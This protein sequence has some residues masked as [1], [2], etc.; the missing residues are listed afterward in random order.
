MSVDE[1][2]GPE[3]FPTTADERWLY[4]VNG[5]N[6][7]PQPDGRPWRA[8]TWADFRDTSEEEPRWL[9][10]GLIPE[11][12]L[13]FTA[14]PPKK[15]KTW[16]A[17]GKALSL[18]TGTALFGEYVV[19]EAVPVLYVALEGSRS[20]LRA[21]IGSLARGMG[22][23][24]DSPIEN[25][26]MLYRPRPF[27][28]AELVSATWLHEEVQDV[29]ARYVVIDVLRAA[30]R[31]QEKD[32]SDF[33]LVRDAL[34]P[35]LIEGVTVDLLHHFGK[36]SDTQKDR[37][38]GERM[39]GTGAMYGALDVGFY[40]TRSENGAR[41]LRVELEA[42]DFATPE[43]IGVVISGTGTG[44]HG[45][46]RYVDTATLMVDAAAAEER[47]LV[48]ET[49]EL[50]ADGEWRTVDEIRK[51]LKANKDE[52]RD[53]LKAS[54]ERFVQID[55]KAVGQH[56]NRKPWGTIAMAESVW[57]STPSHTSHTDE[58]EGS[59]SAFIRVAHPTGE[60]TSSHTNDSSG[61]GSGATPDDDEE[62]PF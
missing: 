36:L 21:R 44:E 50:F 32:A 28:L 18:A 49:E 40:I 47:D 62:I 52:V 43:A 26:H 4:A 30:A 58:N 7:R 5:E 9:V 22:V 60:T 14:A 1:W 35:L 53:M 10:H 57:L 23:D 24:P 25:L 38:P 37:S 31:I 16:L 17:I 11:G 59:Q 3:D 15:G 19:P 2:V 6:S 51:E 20:A 27:N 8:E 54:P 42:R 41:R 13:A 34:E 29:G 33:A 55:A 61:S 46:F 56:W 12:Q 48:A 39:S 45:G